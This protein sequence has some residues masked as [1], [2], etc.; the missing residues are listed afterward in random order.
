MS[1]VI[2]LGAGVA[3]LAAGHEL[4]KKSDHQVTIVEKNPY[5]GGLAVTLKKDGFTFDSGPHRW[6]T[7]SEEVDQWMQDLMRGELVDVDR[8]TR[9]YYNGKYYYYPLKPM[10][11]LKKLRHI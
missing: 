10:N 4:T 7:K 3:G 1:K 8:L 9:I 6:F 5:V 11:A 2:I